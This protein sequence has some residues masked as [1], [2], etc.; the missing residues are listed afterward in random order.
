MS[1]SLYPR[2]QPKVPVARGLLSHRM[3]YLPANFSLLGLGLPCRIL[4]ARKPT[5][6]LPIGSTPC[7][8]WP[9]LLTSRSE[10]PSVNDPGLALCGHARCPLSDSKSKPG[11]H[12]ES[13]AHRLAGSQSWQQ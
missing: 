11:A 9:D 1:W 4:E 13:I 7:S 2:V 5:D 12:S 3:R 6:A 8:A 10:P